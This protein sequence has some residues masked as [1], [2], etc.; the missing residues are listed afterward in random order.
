L[1]LSDRQESLVANWESGLAGPHETQLK[2][3]L[4]VQ[5]LD[6]EFN[7]E[8]VNAGTTRQVQPELQRDAFG[9]IPPNRNH[10]CNFCQRGCTSDF[11]LLFFRGLD[12]LKRQ[13]NRKSTFRITGR[14]TSKTSV[15]VP[16]LGF[17][18]EKHTANRSRSRSVAESHTFMLDRSESF[19][20]KPRSLCR[21][22]LCV[23]AA[24]P[25]IRLSESPKDTVNGCTATI[26]AAGMSLILRRSFSWIPERFVN[27]LNDAEGEVREDNVIAFVGSEFG[28]DP[29][30]PAT[31]EERR[32]G[33]D[34]G[35]ERNRHNQ[36][37]A[38]DAGDQASEA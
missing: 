28:D 26:Q 18:H 8:S 10:D 4:F 37:L 31:H 15:S 35:A 1:T 11:C 29:F 13:G 20:T 3:V 7:G 9:N 12:F 34:S 32:T 6:L 25:S 5:T 27:W 16:F 24:T 2:T 23:P 33:H 21:K 36:R 38:V 22:L 19:R 17:R 14:P 30:V